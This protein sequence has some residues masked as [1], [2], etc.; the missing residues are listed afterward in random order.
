MAAA[1][2]LLSS[3]SLF[4]TSQDTLPEIHTLGAAEL[5]T[6]NLLLIS[7]RWIQYSCAFSIK[8]AGLFLYM[9]NRPTYPGPD[10]DTHVRR[11]GRNKF[12]DPLCFRLGIFAPW[13][14]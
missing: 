4:F 14:K 13:L 2:L 10:P 8:G 9:G 6:H 1:L 3:S 12:A 5:P 7:E 11:D